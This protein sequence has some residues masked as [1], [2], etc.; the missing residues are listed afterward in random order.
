MGNWE[1]FLEAAKWGCVKK[2]P[3]LYTVEPF[4]RLTRM[5]AGEDYRGIFP[6]V[7]LTRSIGGDTVTYQV[8]ES[9]KYPGRGP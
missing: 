6:G 9:M 8:V 5:L 3:R 1:G 2:I 7:T 4:P